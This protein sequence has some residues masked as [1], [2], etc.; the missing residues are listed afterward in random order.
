MS[1][2]SQRLQ[3]LEQRP[4]AAETVNPQMLTP[5]LVDYRAGLSAGVQEAPHS[6]GVAWVDSNGLSIPA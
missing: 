6:I 1:K 5:R 2:V 4:V 3:R